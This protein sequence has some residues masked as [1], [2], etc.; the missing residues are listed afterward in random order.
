MT[1]I[2]HYALLLA[3]YAVA[4]LMGSLVGVGWQPSRF[5]PRESD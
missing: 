1:Q 3:P 4:A 5:R 2:V